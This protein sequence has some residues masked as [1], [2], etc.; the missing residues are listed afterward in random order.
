M[1]GDID[2]RRLVAGLR[3]FL[4]GMHQLEQSLKLLADVLLDAASAADY[5]NI[6]VST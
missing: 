5:E 6:P 2:I 3:L 4:F 1:H